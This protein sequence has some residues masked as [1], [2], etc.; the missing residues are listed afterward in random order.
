MFAYLHLRNKRLEEQIRESLHNVK[1]AFWL[2]PLSERHIQKWYGVEVCNDTH[3]PITVR[4]VEMVFKD[5]NDVPEASKLVAGGPSEPFF[6]QDV[7]DERNFVELPAYIP[8]GNSFQKIIDVLIASEDEL[9][10]GV[11]KRLKDLGHGIRNI[12]RGDETT[13]RGR[14]VRPLRAGLRTQRDR[15]GGEPARR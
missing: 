15:G 14:R 9:G 1:P 5:A 4:M 13:R 12:V 6:V 3:V 8:L 10:Y 7:S 2:R 11:N